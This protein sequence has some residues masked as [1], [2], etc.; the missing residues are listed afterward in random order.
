MKQETPYRENGY[1]PWNRDHQHL[2]RCCQAYKPMGRLSTTKPKEKRPQFWKPRTSVADNYL[3][4][5][6]ARRLA[7]PNSSV[8][9]AHYFYP[10]WRSNA[11]LDVSFKHKLTESKKPKDAPKAAKEIQQIP[12]ERRQILR[13]LRRQSH[14]PL[15]HPRW[16]H[17]D[18]RH[19]ASLR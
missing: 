15:N 1:P 16:A 9:R 5:S 2:D 19:P 11:D 3:H 6:L 12:K 7:L 13:G 14:S 18:L 8:A 17:E 4:R 10:R